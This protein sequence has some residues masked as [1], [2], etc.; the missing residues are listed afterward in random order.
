MPWRRND[1][2]HPFIGK[3]KD[4]ER[5]LYGSDVNQKGRSMKREELY[6]VLREKGIPKDAVSFQGGLPNES[7]CLAHTGTWEVYYSERGKKSGL[8]EF[9]TEEDAC[10]YLYKL[11]KECFRF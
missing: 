5:I 8:K 1:W 3:E 9:D 4:P 11:L 6:A 2:P 7:F 10:E